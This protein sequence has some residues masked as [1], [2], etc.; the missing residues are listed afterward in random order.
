MIGIAIVDDDKG[1]LETAKQILLDITTGYEHVQ[2]D[3]F[4][5][6]AGFLKVLGMHRYQIL[7]SDI[8]MP[9]I[10]GIELCK[11]VREKYLDIYIVFLTAY[12]EFAID[13][14]RMD[15]YQYILKSEIQSRFPVVLG[16]LVDMVVNSQKNF[17][18]IGSGMLKERVLYCDIVAIIKLKKSKYVE[19][20]TI[21]EKLYERN[22]IEKTLEKLN[23]DEFVM[24]ERAC[25]VNLCHV[26]KI[27]DN[28]L[29]LS[30]KMTV[31]AS[32]LRIKE[33]KEKLNRYW[34]EM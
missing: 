13:S 3:T 16:K 28:M 26:T 30:N 34:R 23:S 20:V 19:Y 22:S 31:E 1:T 29:F 12:V 27:Q 18:Y 5:S 7:V 9:G 24:V 17:C 4:Q 25:A 6:A 8:D 14:Y 15:A 11:K 32:S 33:V 10:N 21:N 2:I